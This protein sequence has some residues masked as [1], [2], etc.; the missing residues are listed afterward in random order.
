MDQLKAAI[1]KDLERAAK[2]IRQAYNRLHPGLDIAKDIKRVDE[3][4]DAVY[5]TLLDGGYDKV[6]KK[7]ELNKPCGCPG[8]LA[9]G[10][11]Q[12]HC[13]VK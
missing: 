2:S 11:H 10:V 6:E 9:P 5:E 3:A 4:L 8:N 7:P 12:L 1:K 13:G